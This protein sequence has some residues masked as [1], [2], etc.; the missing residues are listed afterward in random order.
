MNNL[1]QNISNPV[2]IRLLVLIS[3]VSLAWSDSY[4]QNPGYQKFNHL[5]TKDGLSQSSGHAILQDSQGYM[6]FG[7]NSG[8][9]RYNGYEVSVYK[10]NPEDSTTI[11][12][13]NISVIYE[14]RRGNLWVAATGAGL[15]LFNRNKDTFS[16]YKII[17][18]ETGE[19]ASGGISN[20]SVSSILELSNGQ[21]WLGTDHGLNLF[22]RDTEE[23]VHF[24]ADSNDS[25]SISSSFIT[26]LYEDSEGNFLI[27][28]ENGLNIWNPEKEN[29]SSF[30]HQLSGLSPLKGKTINKIYE[31]RGG[32][33]WIGTD[34]GLY[35][36][37][38]E[39][40][41][42]REYKHNPNDNSSISGNII[43][44][45]IEDSRGVLW[46]GTE[47]N[48]L[49]VLERNT[50]KFHHYTH[51][52]DDP[53]S[54][55]DDAIYTLYEN[56]DSI[57]WLGTY[58]GG[59][60]YLD[61]KRSKFEHYKYNSHQE[62]PLSVNSVTSFLE[63]NY[64]NLWVGTDGGGL[65]R[66]N[67]ETGAFYTLRHDPK[68]KNSLSSD[69]V[70]ALLEDDNGYIWIGYYHGGISRYDVKQQKFKHYR[71]VDGDPNSLCHDDVFAFYEDSNGDIWVGTN[72][73]G[74]CKLNPETDKFTHYQAEEGVIRDI[75]EDSRGDIWLGT[76]GGGLKLLNQKDGSVWNFYEG[77]NGLQSNVVLTIH[78]DRENNFWVGTKEGGI[79]LFDR[80]SLKFTHYDVED[81]L[82][83]NEVKGILED[84]HGNLWMSTNKGISKFNT[85]TESFLNFTVEDGLQ[86]DEFNTLAYYKDHSG[87]MYF[88]GINGFNRFHPDSV[89]TSSFSY[90]LVLSDFRIFNKPVPIDRKSPLEKH[91]SQTETLV[92][93][94]DA[95]VLTIEYAALNFNE[96]KGIRY[97]YMLEGFEEEWNYVGNNRSATYT[98]LSPGEYK[99]RV[100]ASNNDEIWS[101]QEAGITLIITPPFWRTTWFYLLAGALFAGIIFGSYRYRMRHIRKRNRWLEEKVK[102]RTEELNQRNDELKEALKTLENTRGELVEKAHKAG[103]ADMATGVL[104]NVGNI[105]NSVKTSSAVMEDLIESSKIKGWF[106]ANEL[107][108]KHE[109]NLGEFFTENP[110]GKQL[111]NYYSKLEQ[112]VKRERSTLMEH[113]ER[114]K[115]KVE[116]IND[117]I[118]AQ[119]S[120]ASSGSYEE[121]I[122]LKKIIDDV[123]T[124][125]TGSSERHGIKIEK[126]IDSVEQVKG[127]RTKLMHILV[128]F[129]KNA[130]EALLEV[131]AEEKKII[132]RL[133]QNDRNVFLSFSDNGSGINKEDLNKIFSHGFTTKANGHG[134]GLHSCANYMSEMGGQIKAES[135]GPG[136]GA[137]FTLVFP[138]GDS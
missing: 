41:D 100:K 12:G 89:K 51:D 124:L 64:G 120:F 66:F 80:D 30:P 110:K 74:V 99:F 3:L 76:Y 59:I 23:F 135:D 60:N 35:A 13:D 56:N 34:E 11:S 109:D 42:I 36:H 103:M 50:G 48:G 128:N 2:A 90:P 69:V 116:L 106:K 65:N 27:G 33:L 105:L 84:N 88:G 81:G 137:T 125:Q 49:N 97:A 20:N 133:F 61:R 82:P 54:L 22:D 5:T 73:G 29:F 16:H 58:S 4:G 118:A 32:M 47:N 53:N 102:K 71:P 123:L 45:I 107:L 111:V 108:Q 79:H 136:E 62:H 77:G 25:T 131:P 70:L 113:N 119:Q 93:P 92:L 96:V 43:F 26:S 75:L 101:E 112:A 83:N 129:Y 17:Y 19:V 18:T 15:N 95:S 31:D 94:Y 63:D 52:L 8:L 28:T 138:R 21:F 57:L 98:N 121:R 46:I 44:S 104:H 87:Y 78:E 122:D 67:R 115:T 55:S 37:N 38:R 10:H 132:I 68:E 9:N 86:G 91:I 127:Q 117:V 114:L 14:D 134:F 39:T 126:K 130:K 40:G 7:T 6:W 85:K 24:L 1:N 72:G